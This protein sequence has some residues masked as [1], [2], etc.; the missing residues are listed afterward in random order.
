MGAVLA[1]GL[2]DAGGRN[3]TLALSSRAGFTK[4][5]AV[6]GVA[7]W[8]Q[9]WYWYPMQHMISLSFAPTALIGLNKEFKMPTKF[10]AACAAKPSLFAYPK[11]TEAKKEDKKERVATVT[12]STTARAKARELRKEKSGLGSERSEDAKSDKPG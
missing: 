1:H 7:L 4:A 6:V 9:H 3:V 5:S 2:I 12:L 10:T 11:M 8:A